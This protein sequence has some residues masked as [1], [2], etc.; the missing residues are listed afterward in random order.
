MNMKRRIVL[1]HLSTTTY[2]PISLILS[3]VC[4]IATGAVTPTQE[5]IEQV[6]KQLDAAKIESARIGQVT[7]LEAEVKKAT[8]VPMDAKTLQEL[9]QRLDRVKLEVAA[10]AG[11]L[12]ASGP[13]SEQQAFGSFKTSYTGKTTIATVQ[14]ATAYAQVNQTNRFKD[15]YWTPHV[16]GIKMSMAQ[17]LGSPKLPD[18]LSSQILSR[19]GGILNIYLSPSNALNT[20]PYTSGEVWGDRKYAVNRHYYAYPY[21]QKNIDVEA[22]KRLD[23]QLLVYWT[24][25]TGV[26]AIK[27]SLESSKAT[28]PT[29]STYGV[30]TTYLGFGFDGPIRLVDDPKA[31]GG[32]GFEVFGAANATNKHVLNRAF[33]TTAGRTVFYT[34]GASARLYLPYH[35]EIAAAYSSGIGAPMRSFVKDVTT[36][37]VAYNRNNESAAQTQ[38]KTSASR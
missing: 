9:Q 2:R 8:A 21:R 23:D 15:S 35:F 24:D 30:A 27:T 18:Y 22:L 33:G 38:S 19:D 13:S 37:S 17:P 26:K 6:Q 20:G 14:L 10:A 3:V 34:W 28:S 25:G 31:T 5:R 32:I 1:L 7:Q 4:S 16:V 29:S 36:F 12:T 11:N